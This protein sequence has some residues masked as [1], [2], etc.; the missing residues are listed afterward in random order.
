MKFRIGQK[1]EYTDW[2]TGERVVLE[3]GDIT[4]SRM[5]CHTVYYETDGIH[6]GIRTFNINTDT[7]GDQFITICDATNNFLQIHAVP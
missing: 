5:V 6:K 2:Q 3:I 4:E 1:F 7:N